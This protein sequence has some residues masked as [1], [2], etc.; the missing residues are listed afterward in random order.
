MSEKQFEFTSE[1]KKK[2]FIWLG[3]GLLLTIIGIIGVQSTFGKGGHG[4][5]HDDAHAKVEKTD[6]KAGHGE[7]KA[8]HGEEKKEASEHGESAHGEKKEAKAEGHGHGSEAHAAH[9]H[10]HKAKEI[11]W[12]TR[13]SADVWHN[14]VLWAGVGVIGLFFLAVQYVGWAGW[15][16][17]LNRVFYAVG[18][19]L[20]PS[21]LLVVVG[22]LVFGKEVFVWTDHDLMHSDHHLHGKAAFLNSTFF[23]AA[24]VICIG[25]WIFFWFKMGK[26]QDLEEREG[27]VIGHKKNM[28]TSSAFMVVFAVSSSLL[29]WFWVMSID[30]Y[31]FSTL[32][33]WYT[34]ASWFVTGL[35]IMTLIILSLKDKGY[36]PK[37][38]ANHIHNMGLFMFA[39]SIFWSYLWF[40]QFILI[41]Y[42]NIPEESA[43]FYDRFIGN[44][45]AYV[46]PTVLTLIIN[47]VF[48]FFFMMTRA[49][50]RS[51]MLLKVAAVMLIL[52]HWMDFYQMIMPG[53][54]KGQGGFD[55]WTIF[56]ELGLF[57][58]FG[59]IFF[60]VV[61]FGLSKRSLTAKNHPLIDESVHHHY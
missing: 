3:I 35:S 13:L 6:A 61:L 14:I 22:F 40:S 4:H 24:S 15:S 53:V 28:R 18:Y 20:I 23:I 39:F 47:F 7:A 25:L 45:G 38:N 59:A 12:F 43:Y 36:L 32:F 5:G 16:I 26:N 10:G 8:E 19:F 48:P 21:L 51:S 44:N 56:L 30:P 41:W 42:A 54:L 60:F 9:G 57:I 50:K 34:F 58:V 33:G 17:L 49:S 52:G 27:G 37:V 11:T 29:A 31:W 2:I 46:W 1:A 55:R